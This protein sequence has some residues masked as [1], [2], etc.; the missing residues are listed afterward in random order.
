MRSGR[1]RRPARPGDQLSVLVSRVRAAVGTDRL[2]RTGGGYALRLDWLDV[3]AAAEL[4]A[5]A[6]RRLAAAAFAPAR[7]A[8]D[9]ALALN[10]GRLL[11]EETGRVVA[12]RP[13][14][15]GP[16]GRRRR[17]AARRRDRAR[18]RRSVGRGRA[19]RA[20]AR[21]RALPRGGPAGA[22]D[23]A[24]PV[25][26]AGAGPW[27][28]MRNSPHVWV[29]SWVWTRSPRPPRCTWLCCGARRQCQRHAHAGRPAGSGP[30][31]RDARR[32]GHGRRLRQGGADAG[33]R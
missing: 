8:V 6:R 3:D 22:H 23:G 25:G 18:G 4:V 1:Q 12:G 15:R 28:P 21:R 26:P 20:G 9:A 11:E 27:P 2:P 14:R 10:R 30:A 33:P 13:A 7:A 5:E 29:T 24:G 17:P 16:P 32:R 19:R 31:A